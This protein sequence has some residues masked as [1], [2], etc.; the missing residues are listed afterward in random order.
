MLEL[1]YIITGTKQDEY[2]IYDPNNNKCPHRCSVTFP[3]GKATISLNVTVMDDK[4]PE[5]DE[6]IYLEIERSSFTFGTVL[7]PSSTIIIKDNDIG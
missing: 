4:M 2:Y 7:Q 1:Y 5:N 3:V 6:K